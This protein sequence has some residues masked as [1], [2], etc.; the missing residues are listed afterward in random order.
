MRTVI[1]GY[2]KFGK[3]YAKRL[4]ENKDYELVG[5]VEPD[6][7]RSDEAINDDVAHGALVCPSLSTMLSEKD[8]D[9]VIVA[10]QPEQHKTVAA[11]AL[12]AYKDVMIAKPGTMSGAELAYLECLINTNDTPQYD[13]KL[14]VDYT[15]LSMPE[16]NNLDLLFSQLGEPEFVS[17]TRCVTGSE[18]QCGV[19]LD[20]FSHD[21]MLF[22]YMMGALA[23]DKLTVSIKKDKHGA[24][25]ANIKEGDKLV[26]NMHAAYECRFATRLAEFAIEPH[27]F[28]ND[29]IRLITWDQHK[30]SIAVGGGPQFF[31]NFNKEMDAVSWSLERFAKHIPNTMY[32][33]QLFQAHSIMRAMNDSL[34]TGEPEGVQF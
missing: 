16:V 21:V 27:S 22:V 3:V 31:I 14:F 8:F 13:G 26:A 25:T 18:P 34:S 7:Y 23:M 2:G 15:L 28:L 17:T 33:D 19:V 4:A 5:I 29:E 30:R 1:A 24:Y 11:E 12:M 6:P 10:T 9:A 32:Y 20:L